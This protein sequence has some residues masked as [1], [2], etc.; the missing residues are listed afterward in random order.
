[1]INYIWLALI[2]IGILTALLQGKTDLVT[3]AAFDAANS[4]VELSIGL[5]GIMTLWLGLMKL[6]EASGIVRFI[7]RVLKPIMKRLFPQ[8]PEDHPAMGSMVMNMAANLLG[9][10]N[11]ATPWVLKP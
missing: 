3:T 10:G 7:G 4:A 6:A 8:V 2:V 5:V 9:L 1:M 11:A